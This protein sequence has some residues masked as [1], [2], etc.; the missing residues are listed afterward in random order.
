MKFNFVLKAA[1]LLSSLTLALAGVA[2]AANV[3]Q[4]S[5]AAKV[6]MV[7]YGDYQCPFTKRSMGFVDQLRADYGD[8]LAIYYA[9]FPLNFHEQALPA[10][11]AAVCADEQGMFWEYSKAL[12]LNQGALASD[13]YKKLAGEM[14]VPDIKAF[15]N[16]MK[17]P[18]TKSAVELE[19]MIGEALGIKGTPHTFI[20]GE[21]VSGAYPYLH[22]KE[23]IDAKLAE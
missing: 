22:I 21:S 18:K 10:A 3:I 6:R 8:D 16:C 23:I 11:I 5:E 13:Y 2:E 20:N 14:K 7:I 4:T 12:F 17:N 9:H 15:E 1:F 19:H